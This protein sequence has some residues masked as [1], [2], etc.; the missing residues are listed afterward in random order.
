LID[1]FSTGAYSPYYGLTA[2]QTALYGVTSY[3]NSK[4]D[5]CG[6]VFQ[7]VRH[8]HHWRATTLHAFSC[9]NGGGEPNPVVV[10]PAT[11]DVWGSTNS[12]SYGTVFRLSP[13]QVGG[14]WVF[15]T[16]YQFQGGA[17]GNLNSAATPLLLQGG[18]A[19]GVAS[20]TD[21]GNGV[22]YYSLSYSG[23]A[24]QKTVLATI[25]NG[26]ADALVGFDAAGAAYISTYEPGGVGD[27]YQLAPAHGGGWTATD[28][29][30]FKP[31]H[32][33]SGI[34][35]LVLDS[36]GNVFGL[37]NRGVRSVVFELAPPSGGGSKWTKSFIADPAQRGYGLTSLALG[38]G[39]NLVGS[40]Y[41]DQ[42]AFGGAAIKLS[43]PGNGGGA[44]TSTV[45]WD[46]S[47]RGPDTNPVSINVGPYGAYYGVL[48]NTY[49]NGA[50]FELKP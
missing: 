40:I 34:Y 20:A 35:N 29:A 39:G 8:G 9:G 7:L 3:G 32:S 13:P 12:G 15:D 16:I 43:P 28:I 6:S 23:S 36:S 18:S 37:A 10:D 50:V 24:W 44:W 17:D 45:L 14:A 11:G 1:T 27:V 38:L 48:N 30:H 2:T 33:E 46:F 47:R 49:D 21:G 19:C 5:A 26:T 41:G 22:E 4:N 25:A 31:G 42:D